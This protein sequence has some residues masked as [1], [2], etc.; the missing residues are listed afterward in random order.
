MEIQFKNDVTSEG[1]SIENSAFYHRYVLELLLDLKKTY[2]KMNMEVPTWVLNIETG[3]KKFL[4][5]LLKSNGHYPLFGDTYYQNNKMDHFKRYKDSIFTL[6]RIEQLPKSAV[7]PKS[8]Y[9]IFR[10]SWDSNSSYIAFTN[11]SLSTVHKHND[12]L[13]FTYF[14]NGEDLIVDAGHIGYEDKKL[15]KYFLSTI[16]HSTITA[17]GLNIEN[18]RFKEDEVAIDNYD[19]FADYAYI[20]GSVDYSHKNIFLDRTMLI[21]GDSIIYLHDRISHKKIFGNYKYANQIFNLGR[22]SNRPEKIKDTNFTVLKTE[23][24]KNDLSFYQLDFGDGR[25]EIFES[26]STQMRG[27]NS[28][29]YNILFY[30]KQLEFSKPFHNKATEFH[31]IISTCKKDLTWEQMLDYKKMYEKKYLQNR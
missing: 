6:D 5:Y 21:I 19:I 16:S 12:N 31:T 14:K 13:S 25:I 4:V 9:A 11:T 3:M 23:F 22:N 10:N 1:V 26:D 20:S 15:R 29:G 28:D 24:E 18:G 17:D 2:E 27:C 30:G 8:G 7:Y